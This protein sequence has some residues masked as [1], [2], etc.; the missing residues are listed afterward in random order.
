[1]GFNKFNISC[2]EN[3][4]PFSYRQRIGEGA[5]FNQTG[6]GQDYSFFSSCFLVLLLSTW[7]LLK[8]SGHF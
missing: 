3:Q 2:L 4:S 6:I 1:M 7:I 5:D 8:F